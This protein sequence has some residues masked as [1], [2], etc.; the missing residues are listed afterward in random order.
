[1]GDKVLLLTKDLNVTRDK[2]LVPCFV[3]LFSIVY[4]I[5]LVAYQLNLGTRYSQVHPI[6]C[7]SP[8]KPFH[9]GGDGYP[10]LT[11]VYTKDKQKQEVSG[12][13]WHKGSGKKRNYL[14]AY[15]G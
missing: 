5:G 3:G 7:I 9:A 11:V 15:S 8:L 2:K 4:W 13:L 10:H 6:F 12:I 14:I 1:M